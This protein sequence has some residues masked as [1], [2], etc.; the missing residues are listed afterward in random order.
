MHPNHKLVE[1]FQALCDL[2]SIPLS[3][4]YL[5]IIAFGFSNNGEDLFF[6]TQCFEI[7]FVIRVILMF[8]TTYEDPITLEIAT[9]IRAVAYNYVVNGSFLRH[10]L[11]VFPF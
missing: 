4:I 8:I 5:W 2:L 1:F 7:V 10:F 3:A 9:S 11:S 6:I